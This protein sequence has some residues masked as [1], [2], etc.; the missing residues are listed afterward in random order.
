MSHHHLQA[1]GPPLQITTRGPNNVY[2]VLVG[3]V[4]GPLSDADNNHVFIPVRVFQGS[5]TGL[6]KIA[7]NVES[8]AKPK[9]AQYFVYDEVVEDADFP[10]QGF[11]A[12]A[13]LSYQE[14]DLKQRQFKTI[15]NGLLRTVVHSTV[16][17]SE[18][19]AAYGFTFP[20]GGLH[21]IHYNNG[22]RP[23]S[24]HANHPNQDG[25]LAVYYHNKGGQPVRRWI[26]IKFQSQKL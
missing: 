16:D 19:L 4:D 8:N 13:S 18:L 10:E 22:E 17:A 2:G 7:F 20:G 12:D 5:G 24:H 1:L 26:F 23:G 25:A 21:D 3:K 9:A 11:S 14:L 15:K 6:H